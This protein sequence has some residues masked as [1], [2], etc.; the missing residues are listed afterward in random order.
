MVVYRYAPD[1]PTAPPYNPHTFAHT[2]E[3]YVRGA[4]EIGKVTKQPTSIRP[5]VSVIYEGRLIGLDVQAQVG[6]QVVHTSC[7]TK[8]CGRI[9]KVLRVRNEKRPKGAACRVSWD[10]GHCHGD[11]AHFEESGREGY[12]TGANDMYALA[13]VALS[14]RDAAA[15]VAR[16]PELALVAQYETIQ[17]GK[18]L[19]PQIGLRVVLAYQAGIERSL[20]LGRIC[21]VTNGNESAR[22]VW[23][24]DGYSNKL[25]STGFRGKYELDLSTEHAPSV[26]LTRSPST[27]ESA[28]SSENSRLLVRNCTPIVQDSIVGIHEKAQVGLRVRRRGPSQRGIGGTVTQV[29]DKALCYVRW[30]DQVSFFL[31]LSLSLSLARALSLSNTHKGGI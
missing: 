18:H 23:D 13:I 27:A 26:P 3:P 24:N 11:P 6:M 20:E 16:D 12:S 8:G 17:V 22:V 10:V 14:A 1:A 31:S 15:A 5:R 30:D 29:F 4:P 2:F 7:P 21:G 28:A 9:T 25:Y 19:P